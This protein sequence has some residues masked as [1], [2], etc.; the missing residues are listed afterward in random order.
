MPLFELTPNDFRPIKEA[1]FSELKIR[2]RSDLQR[3]L[4]GQ[5]QVLGEDLY[6]LAEE[7]GDWQDSKRRID[8]LALDKEAN[9]VVIELKRTADGGHMDLQALRYA[10]MVST[11]TFDRA[12]QVHRTYLTATKGE[13]ETARDRVLEFLGWDEPEEADFAE[14]VRIFLVAEDFDK[15]ITSTVLWLRERDIDVRCIRLRPYCEGSLRLV[16]VQ[17]LIP[18]PEAQDFQIQLRE[19]DQIGRKERMERHDLRQ[20]FWEGLIAV[21]RRQQ[22]RHANI[23]PGTHNFLGTSSGV[24]GLSF[25]YVVVQD[26]GVAELY[27]DRGTVTEN[28]EIFARLIDRREA[29]ENRF[30][31]PLEW[32]RLDARRACRIKFVVNRG[33]YRSA[34]SQWPEIHAEMVKAM[35]SLETAF[36]PEITAL[37]L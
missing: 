6:V 28:K 24:R 27:I 1:S 34:E 22:T 5:I 33:G 10:A 30:G 18:L 26:Y 35:S 32:Q 9:L 25:N 29:V 7:F 14:D 2:E 23:K 19:K 4:R 12:V 15:E 17:P 20:R 13:P 36:A 3:L 31:G 16:D 8:L 21:A 37:G 11:M